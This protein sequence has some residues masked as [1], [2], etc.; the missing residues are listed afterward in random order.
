MKI[1]RPLKWLF[2]GVALAG[3]LSEGAR[4]GSMQD[5]VFC[6]SP[7]NDLYRVVSAN[8]GALAARFQTPA[9]T[10]AAAP[11]GG[12][13]LILADGYP[14]TATALDASLYDAAARKRLKMYVEYP[15]FVPG[16][17]LSP[18]RQAHW[19]RTVVTSDAFGPALAQG[20]ILMIHDCHFLPT[21]ASTPYL[22]L[23]RVAGFDTAVNGLPKKDI[24]PI[25]FE[26]PR[27]NVLVATTKL[28]QFVSARYGPSDAWPVTWRMILG[29]L[30]PSAREANLKWASTVHPSYGAE[31]SLPKDAAR[32]AISRGADWYFQARLLVHQDWQGMI[33]SNQTDDSVHSGPAPDMPP[34]DGRFGL[35]EGFSSIV[36]LDGTQPMRWG[37][38]ADCNCECSMALAIQG[39]LDREARSQMAASNLLDF[40]FYHS[41]LSQGRRAEPNNPS[42]GLLGWGLPRSADVYYGDDN[43]RAILGALGAAAALKSS[44]WD[45][46]ILRGILANFR[47]TGPSGYRKARIDDPELQTQGWQYFWQKS[48]GEWG[49]TRNCP[50]YQAYLWAVYLWLYDK[51]HF[52]PL[53]E[54]TEKA[55]RHQMSL[56]PDH[57]DHEGG[58]YETERCRMLLPLAWL[59]RVSNTPEHR[60]WL[61][62]MVQYVMDIQDGSGAIPQHV[63]RPGGSNEQY[64][65]AECPLIY[66]NGDPCTDLL[67]AANF[68]LIG[69]HE[70]VAA[71]GD[72]NWRRAED[73]LADFMIR[74]QVRGSHAEL[75][76]AWFHG[77]DF[78]RW[79]YWGSNG[80]IGWGVWATE[81][82]WT[83]GWIVA[84]LGLREMKT[85]LWDFTAHSRMGKLMPVWRARMLPDDILSAPEAEQAAHAAL[86]CPVAYL[87]DPDSRYPDRGASSLTDGKLATAD[88]LDP[89]WVGWEGSDMEAVVSLGHGTNIETLA[90]RFLESIPVGIYLPKEVEFAVSMNG[91]D[92]DSVGTARRTGAIHGTA[93]VQQFELKN[94]RVFAK[95]VRVRALNIGRIPAGQPAAG[96]KAWLFTD[97]VLVNPRPK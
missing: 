8:T 77:F 45:E 76:G 30:E 13:V 3:A 74:V 70:A 34:G 88:Y 91:K 27:G 67:Y 71:T 4:G 35:L 12:G 36:N 83:Q 39:Q 81:T 79:D 54:R 31:E 68:G 75:D 44:H 72:P 60:R 40:V 93:T 80:D 55:I 38:R 62:T 14:D 32:Q 51:T 53:L 2:A 29:W 65:T 59:L 22:T 84:A 21:E 52:A 66:E 24:W 16:I 9:A 50:H 25:L 61:G 10:V 46:A 20:R 89:G 23:A 1:Q 82:G 37:I 42:Y 63:L 86:R 48:R 6:C 97:E 49:G 17:K 11:E 41:L 85:S 47:T 95:F 7:S 69:L 28:S 18:P 26:L 43:A 15:S 78:R 33:E 64:G 5:L 57:W 73:R 19:E 92:F 94:L 87:I 56:Y 96:S 90:S 58:R